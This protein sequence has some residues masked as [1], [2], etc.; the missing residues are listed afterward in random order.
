MNISVFNALFFVISY[1]VCLSGFFLF[2]KKQAMCSGIIWGTLSIVLLMGYHTLICGVWKLISGSF[3]M[4]VIALMDL[5]LGALCWYHI[6]KNKTIQAYEWHRLD[7]VICAVL[8]LV[9]LYFVY[10]EFTFGLNIGYI[11]SDP[12]VHYGLAMDALRYGH[13]TGMFFAEINNALFIGV[14]A[15]FLTSLIYCY[16]LFILADAVMFFMSG[17]M[18]YA[19][20]REYLTTRLTQALGVFCVILYMVGYPLN[21]ML[22]GFIYLGMS[23]TVIAFIMIITK[24]YL[25]DIYDKRLLIVLLSIGVLSLVLCYMLFAPIV[26]ITVCGCLCRYYWKKQMLF[27]KQS[28]M[29]ILSI[30]LIPTLMAFKFCFLDYFIGRDLDITGTIANEGGIYKDF[31]SNFI[32]FLPFAVYGLSEQVKAKKIQLY[33]CFTLIFFGFIMIMFVLMY[34]GYVSEY[35]YFKTYYPFWLMYFILVVKGMVGVCK[36]PKSVLLS[37]ASIFLVIVGINRLNLERRLL[38]NHPTF[39]T[40]KSRNFMDIYI[41][42]AESLITH[43]F[44]DQRLIDLYRYAMDECME[45]SDKP[46]PVYVSLS[47]YEDWYWFESFSGMDSSMF[48]TWN[49]GEAG[50]QSKIRRGDADYVI[51][52][53]DDPMYQSNPGFI[54]SYRCVYQNEVGGIYQIEM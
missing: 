44:Y 54:Q 19:L 51:V 25:E 14:F 49:I 35:Y 48:Y 9:V 41:Y 3:S 32:M 39:T 45:Q 26:W 53:Y 5:A 31:F 13:T 16:K 30:F 38:I 29:V 47:N 10:R 37:M 52:K 23:V 50:I 21:N 34:L 28:V 11:T 2:P 27:S 12:G 42:N 6:G 17:V 4:P 18:F 36:L 43:E 40:E 15:P 7:N 8:G 22:F 1:F 33:E 46:I 20:I 24:F